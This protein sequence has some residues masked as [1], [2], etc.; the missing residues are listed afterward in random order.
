MTPITK[1]YTETLSTGWSQTYSLPAG[2]RLS[3]TSWNV[4]TEIAH[5]SSLTAA[6]IWDEDGDGKKLT[7]IDK[8]FTKKRTYQ[9][10]FGPRIYVSNGKSRVIVRRHIF[11]Q[12]TP[13]QIYAS[14]SGVLH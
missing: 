6:L 7:Y 14:W 5:G 8:L 4:G 2:A 11:G 10:S 9:K 1:S 13:R 12:K 3:F